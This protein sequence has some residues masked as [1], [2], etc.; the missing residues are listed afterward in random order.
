MW[1]LIKMWFSRCEF[2]QKMW[3]WKCEFCQKWDFQNVN[4]WINWGCLPQCA[5]VRVCETLWYFFKHC[6]SGIYHDEVGFLK[7]TCA[8][9]PIVLC[10]TNKVS[11]VSIMPF[12][13]QEAFNHPHCTHLDTTHNPIDQGSSSLVINIKHTHDNAQ[14]LPSSVHTQ[15]SYQ[16]H[17]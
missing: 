5:K 10:L 15:R 11:R 16:Q 13:F 1:S 9:S 3:F 2:C 8:F 4:F 14:L 17:V 6:V 12:S 7:A